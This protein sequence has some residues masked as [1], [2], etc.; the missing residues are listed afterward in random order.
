MYSETVF[1][2]KIIDY[3]RVLADKDCGFGPR[4][5]DLKDPGFLLFTSSS[6]YE[7]YALTECHSDMAHIAR[8]YLRRLALLQIREQHVGRQVASA[9]HLRG[10]SLSEQLIVYLLLDGIT[11]GCCER[12]LEGPFTHHHR[13]AQPPRVKQFTC[14]QVVRRRHTPPLAW[15]Q[16]GDRT[17]R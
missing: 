15:G 6:E 12:Q 11:R 2:S 3:H 4:K 16:I 5:I 8:L 1:I 13:Q 10:L 7:G 17:A 14:A 9:L